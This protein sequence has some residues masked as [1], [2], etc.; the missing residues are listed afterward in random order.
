MNKARRKLVCALGTGAFAAL[1]G[2]PVLS[3]AALAVET[4]KLS[5]D[6]PAAKSLEYTHLSPDNAKNCAGCQFYT[7]ADAEWGPCTIF[8]DKLVSARGLCKSWYGRA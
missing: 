6:D 4:P 2:N 5:P 1:L 8:P 7:G 3:A